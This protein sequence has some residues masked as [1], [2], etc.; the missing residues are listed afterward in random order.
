[1]KI[2]YIYLFFVCLFL[3]SC[4][5]VR[6]VAEKKIVPPVTENKLLKSIENNTLE[7]TTL[8]AKRIE[9]SLKNKKESGH[10]RATLKIQR[11]SFIQ[12]SVTAPLGIEVA[13]VLLT[14]DSIK[15]A[16]LYHKK[17]FLTDY[18]FFY[19]K[20]DARVSFDCVEKILTNTFF[21]F[22]DCSGTGKIKKYK[23]E[24]VDEGY[25]L[26]SIEEKALSRKIKKFYKKK[27]KNKD[28]ILILQKILIDPQIY[29]PL[30]M[31]VEDVDEDLGVSVRY[32]NFKRFSDKIFPEKILFE[33]SSDHQTTS[34]ELKFVRLEFEIPVEANFRI[35]PKFKRME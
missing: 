12:V 25:E 33:L 35:S 27:R 13:R 29:R 11:D 15:F 20:F 4:H 2:G 17:Y 32:E 18:N 28:Y 26:S 3:S 23:L 30:A 22:E 21:N 5:T 16:D 6:Q 8:Y 34:L 31:S 7:Y 24:R 1:M 19:D 10:F 9:I 14:R